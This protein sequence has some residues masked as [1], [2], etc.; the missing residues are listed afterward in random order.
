MRIRL[1]GNVRRGE[2]VNEENVWNK[3]MRKRLGRKISLEE[4]IDEGHV[5]NKS[6][7]KCLGGKIRLEERV[8]EENIWNYK[9]MF[10]NQGTHYGHIH[11]APTS[12]ALIN[13]LP[14]IAPLSLSFSS[15]K[16][17][18]LE[19]LLVSWQRLRRQLERQNG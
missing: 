5:W 9:E 16:S 1:G 10:Y 11:L 6:M 8:S 17:R 4:Q 19:E 15:S 3:S 18:H 12:S 13:S 7:R 14:L 2:Q